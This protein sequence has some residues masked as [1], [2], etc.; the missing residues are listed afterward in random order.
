MMRQGLEVWAGL[1]EQ[2]R[3]MRHPDTSKSG[4]QAL[5]PGLQGQREKTAVTEPRESWNQGADGVREELSS[6]GEAAFANKGL[7]KQDGN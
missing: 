4:Q 3:Q 7:I 1:W 2:M 5:P 6:W